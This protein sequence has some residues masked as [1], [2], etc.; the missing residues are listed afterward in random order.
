MT[1]WLDSV[2]RSRP[3]PVARAHGRVVVSSEVLRLTGEVLRGFRGTDGA[4][5]GMVLWAG[6]QQHGNA[7][8]EFLVR[9]VCDHGWGHVKADE[10]AILAA[11]REARAR[12]AA[13]LVQVHSHPGTDT[14]HSDG[15][16]RLVLM[17]F[18]GMFSLVVA[19]YGLGT[20]SPATGVGVHQ[21]QDGRWTRVEA[22]ALVVRDS[23]GPI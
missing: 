2:A 6:R 5:E 13:V 21:F 15:D 18:E 22:G 19:C 11:T 8:I 14:R 9:P 4:H 12:R 20:H 3:L 23:E 7:L 16:D 10:G 17:P 1:S